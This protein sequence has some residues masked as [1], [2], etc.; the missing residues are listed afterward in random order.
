[1]KSKLIT[2][3]VI[4]IGIGLL[5]QGCVPRKIQKTYA[6]KKF[7][8]GE[9]KPMSIEPVKSD[10]LDKM[11]NSH[12]MPVKRVQPEYPRDAARHRITGYAVVEFIVGTDG[13]VKQIRALEESPPDV[14][15]AQASMIAVSQW[16]YRPATKDGK[17]VPY[18]AEV[19]MTF[20]LD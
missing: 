10:E 12:F 1:M 8:R 18:I 4:L 6:I 13:K 19:R 2:V 5:M 20:D 14:G 7:E 17:P 3:N 16:T 11:P 9:F 15:F